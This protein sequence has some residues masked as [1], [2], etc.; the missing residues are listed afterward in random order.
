MAQYGVCVSYPRNVREKKK[1]A[2]DCAGRENVNIPTRICHTCTGTP[3]DNLPVCDIELDS[4]LALQYIR[5]MSIRGYPC[6]CT[7]FLFACMDALRRRPEIC[8][9][10]HIAGTIHLLVCLY[11][12]VFGSVLLYIYVSSS[13]RNDYLSCEYWTGTPASLRCENI[14]VNNTIKH[15]MLGDAGPQTQI[16]VLIF[17]TQNLYV[18]KCFVLFTCNLQPNYV[19][20]PSINIIHSLYDASLQTTNSCASPLEY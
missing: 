20:S 15:H 3:F 5:Y 4:S 2:H 10:Q 9:R 13:C 6:S 17:S 18:W 12:K 8:P 19:A 1:L 11:W 7:A 14:W 16:L